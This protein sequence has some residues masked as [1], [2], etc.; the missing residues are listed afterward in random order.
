MSKNKKINEK[1]YEEKCNKQ[2]LEI[3]NL[4][5]KKYL[6]KTLFGHL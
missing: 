1:T 5:E 4:K 3:V 6:I 2:S